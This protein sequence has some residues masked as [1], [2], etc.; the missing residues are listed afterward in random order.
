MLSQLVY[1]SIRDT[2]CSNEEVSQILEASVANNGKRDITGVLVYSQT[3]FL[4]VLEGNQH[5]IMTLFDQI[6]KDQRHS[7]ALL[8]S[9]KQIDTRYFPSW[10]MVGK[11]IDTETYDFL[12]AMEEDEKKEFRALIHG[13]SKN[14]A[15]RMIAKLFKN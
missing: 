7:N 11:A 4:Q 6:K 8:L 5:H 14:N 1:L 10:Q 13:E 9:A 15:A 12:T 2:S 3:K